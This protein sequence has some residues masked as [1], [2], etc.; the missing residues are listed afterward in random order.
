MSIR[1]FDA[2]SGQWRIWWL[3]LSNPVIEQP[4]QGA[5]ANGEGVF[6]GDDTY[7][8]RPIK[9]RYHWTDITTPSP[10]WEQTWS[11]DGGATW[12][13]NWTMRFSPA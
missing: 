12:E 10:H 11:A 2:T 5:F 8:G 7:N 9:V 4:V 6:L 1:A 13:S 3:S